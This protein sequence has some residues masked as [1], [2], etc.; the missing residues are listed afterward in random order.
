[1]SDFRLDPVGKYYVVIAPERNKRPKDVWDKSKKISTK[2]PF[3]P[4]NE[5]LTP[6]ASFSLKDNLE[7][8]TVRSFPNKYPAFKDSSKHIS[9]TQEVIVESANHSLNMGDY[10]NGDLTN[11]LLAYKNRISSLKKKEEIKYVIVF[12]NHGILAGASLMH[13]HSQIV[14][15]GLV[16][17]EIRK[18]TKVLE[19]LYQQNKQCY[20]CDLGKNSNMIYE[21]DDFVSFIPETARFSYECWITPKTHSTYFEQ[22]NNTQLGS[23]AEIILKLLGSI[24]KYLDFPALNLLVNTGFDRKT[25]PFFHWNIQIIPRTD[26]LAG[27]ELATGLYINQVKPSHAADHLKKLI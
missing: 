18:Q 11:V 7:K 16:P 21:N 17:E 20:Y 10:S 3:C 8:W 22:L 27:F 13:S 4:G 2:C 24:N 6:Q 9:G 26:Q 5:E 23:L 1:M 12:K 15:L 25:E 14:G 19:S